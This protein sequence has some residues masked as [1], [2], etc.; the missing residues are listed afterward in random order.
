LIWLTCN[1]IKNKRNST[2]ESLHKSCLEVISQLDAAFPKSSRILNPSHVHM[3]AISKSLEL[4]REQKFEHL[5]H[6]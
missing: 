3:N 2:T 6:Y 4:L 5:E 1:R